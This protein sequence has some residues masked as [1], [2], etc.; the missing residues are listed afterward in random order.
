MVEDILLVDDCKTNLLILEKIIRTP[1]IKTYSVTNGYDA[2]EKVKNKNIGIIF[3][4][5]QM[6]HMDGYELSRT[7]RGM[8]FYMPIY[9]VTT[10]DDCKERKE[11]GINGHIKKPVSIEKFRNFLRYSP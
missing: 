7:V 8:G 5:I 3:T 10:L 1:G 4:D 9:A 2:I 11:A 6:P